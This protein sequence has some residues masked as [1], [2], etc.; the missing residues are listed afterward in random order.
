MAKRGDPVVNEQI[1]EKIGKLLSLAT[2][3]VEE[4]A[5]AAML[6]AQALMAAHNL[7]LEQVA[8]FSG[9]SDRG[10]TGGLGQGP[11]V[12][13]T[14]E[15]PARTIQYW[16]KLLTSV[17]TENFRCA[18]VYRSYRNG[19]RDIVIIGT[20]TDVAVCRETLVFSFHSAI[21]CW[22]RY[23]ATRTFRS[24]RSLEASKRDYMIGFT[25]GLRDA[26]AAQVKEKAIVLVRPAQVDDHL[27]GMHLRSEPAV[28]RNFMVDR[29]AQRRGYEE[30]RRDRGRL[31][32]EGA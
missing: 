16:Q 3:D 14:V 18:C 15:K 21:N 25:R 19:S 5:R 1:V 11:V 30:G 23:R 6:K 29:H 27:S 12:E 8:T 2:S 9:G 4:E 22:S 7:S 17:V 31:L 13:Q 28:R 24:R 32:E 26:F 10:R 20:P